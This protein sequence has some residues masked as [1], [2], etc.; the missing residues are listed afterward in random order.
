LCSAYIV[1]ATDLN[2]LRGLLN[3]CEFRLLLHLNDPRLLLIGLL[4]HLNNLRL[5]LDCKLWLL[6]NL[7]NLRLLLNL[8]LGLLLHLNNLR[9]LLDDNLWLRLL[10]NILWLFNY[11]LWLL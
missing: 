11:I 1:T 10:H 5:L 7:D 9:L 4:L 6:L 8:V 3:Y 2:H